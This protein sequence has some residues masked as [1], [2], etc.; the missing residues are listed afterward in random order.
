LVVAP[1]P[2][3]PD[4]ELVKRVAAIDLDGRLLLAGDAQDASTDS[5]TF[6]AIDPAAIRGRPWFRVRPLERL[7]RVG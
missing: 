5:R 3:Q 4:R 2:R 1:D 7:G 6:V